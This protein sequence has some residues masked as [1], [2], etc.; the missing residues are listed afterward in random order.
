MTSRESGGAETLETQVRERALLYEI[1]RS[2]SGIIDLDR[3]LPTMI[4]R[5]K[6]AFAVESSAVLLVDPDTSE[7]YFPHISDIDV[8]TEEKFAAIRIP[9]GQGIAGWVVEHGRTECVRDVRSDPR[10][11]GSVDEESGMVSHSVLCTPLRGRDGIV[12]VIELRNKLSGEF[13][14]ED[15]RLLESLAEAIGDALDN[16]LRFERSRQAE[17]RLRGELATLRRQRARDASFRKIVGQSE[18]MRKIFRLMESAIAAPVTVLLQ[19]ETGTGKELVA[20]AIHQAGPRAAYPFVAINCGGLSET[21]LESELFGHNRGAFTG[22]TTS[23]AGVFEVADRGTIFLDEVGDMPASMQIKLLRVLQE[24]EVVRVGESKPRK[25]DVRVISASHVDLEKAVEEGRFRGDLFFRLSTFPIRLPPLRERP[26][27]IGLI[28]LNLLERTIEKFGGGPRG[29]SPQVLAA[30]QAYDWP[31]NVRELQNEI[32]R[33]AALANSEEEISLHHLSERLA[34]ALPRPMTISSLKTAGMSLKEAR[35][36]FERE[37]IAQVLAE[38][39]GN[40]VQAA[41][42]LGISRVMLQTKIRQYDL[43][44]EPG[45]P[46]PSQKRAK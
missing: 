5:T 30:L 37:Y 45:N 12:G 34:V 24:G 1:E 28:A 39:R 19:G 13:G 4:A 18:A 35:Q 2:F 44:R 16:S 20:N 9:P 46:R 17:V 42:A 22:A 33:A 40:A 31:G 7:L 11:Y 6:A 27:D 29:F 25:V 8:A 23:R 41:K 14:P 21:L 36:L 38:H 3:L 15:T 43:R 32:E 10:W 26:E